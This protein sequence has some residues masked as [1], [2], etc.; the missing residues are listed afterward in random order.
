MNQAVLII[1]L[2]GIKPLAQ[3]VDVSALLNPLDRSMNGYLRTCYLRSLLGYGWWIQYHRMLGSMLTPEF[4]L[5]NQHEIST[6]RNHS[7]QKQFQFF[8]LF[9]IPSM[10]Y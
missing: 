10:N 1:K 4:I 6:L 3:A 9:C 5:I 8:K 7:Q 2:L